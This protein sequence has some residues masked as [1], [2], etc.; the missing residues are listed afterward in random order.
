M[1][2]ASIDLPADMVAAQPGLLDRVF[3]FAFDVLGLVTID[4]RIRANGLEAEGE[5][6]SAILKHKEQ[7]Q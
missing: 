7:P 1:K 4:I 5:H 2:R 6:I 3:A